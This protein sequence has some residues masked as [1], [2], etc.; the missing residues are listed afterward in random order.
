MGSPVPVPLM[1]AVSM[2]LTMAL[3]M[4]AVSRSSNADRAM[5]ET[6][7]EMET[8]Q[9]SL[10]YAKVIFALVTFWAVLPLPS[11]LPLSVLPVQV[12]VGL[13]TLAG[14]ATPAG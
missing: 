7:M 1:M 12:A 13:V 3:A 2:A 11:P 10:K 8:S 5:V 14:T 9:R 4:L 6:S